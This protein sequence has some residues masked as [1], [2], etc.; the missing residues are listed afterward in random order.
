[1]SDIVYRSKRNVAATKVVRPVVLKEGGE[2]RVE[3]GWCPG[4][5]N[6]DH[7]RGIFPKED[8]KIF[9]IFGENDASLLDGYRYSGLLLEI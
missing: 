9:D 8:T 6:A 5:R 3:A 7:A 1:L 4:F 2:F